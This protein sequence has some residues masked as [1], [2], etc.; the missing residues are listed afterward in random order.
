MAFLPMVVTSNK[1]TNNVTHVGFLFCIFLTLRDF[2]LLLADFG[3]AHTNCATRLAERKDS[4]KGGKKP[5]SECIAELTSTSAQ[6]V[7]KDY[8]FPKKK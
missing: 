1:Q 8:F 4:R 2:A 3:L 7:I 6:R 5:E